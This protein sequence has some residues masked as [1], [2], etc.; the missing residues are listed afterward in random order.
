MVRGLALLAAAIAVCVPVSASELLAAW[1]R[2]FEVHTWSS[3]NFDYAYFCFDYGAGDSDAFGSPPG[4]PVWH[5]GESGSYAFDAGYSQFGRLAAGLTDGQVGA[6]IGMC[7]LVDIPDPSGG[8]L[9]GFGAGDVESHILGHYPDLV[10][11]AI[12]QIVLQVH[13]FSM[14]QGNGMLD[15]EAAITW[16]IW[17]TPVPEPASAM[18]LAM[19]LLLR[20]R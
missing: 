20:R 6:M 12:D 1:P 18:A 19:G 14:T 10:G 17:G 2:V 8:T 16:E 9:F 5:D 13:S 15:V 4:P 3:A 11:Y 7:W